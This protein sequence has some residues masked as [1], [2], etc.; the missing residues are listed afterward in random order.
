MSVQVP[1]LG[2]EGRKCIRLRE[3]E[4]GEVM[5]RGM[6]ALLGMRVCWSLVREGYNSLE[7]GMGLWEWRVGMGGMGLG[8]EESR[9]RT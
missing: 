1:A 7:V 5:L 2:W 8:G 3:K 9:I 4:D 6:L